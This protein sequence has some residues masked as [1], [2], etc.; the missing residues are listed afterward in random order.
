MT[1]PTSAILIAAIGAVATLG[2]TIACS[3]QAREGAAPAPAAAAT[4]PAKA[5]VTPAMLERGAQLYKGTCAVCHGEQ[6]RGDGPAASALKPPPRDHTDRAYMST[7]TD[8]DL[9]KV[10]QI[11]GVLK[12]KP[13]MPGSP[14]IKGADLDALVAYVRSLSAGK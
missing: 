4:K 14:Q 7:L 10:I 13:L 5:A 3:S 1:K 2:L 6:G 8:E 9:A 12:N 11:G